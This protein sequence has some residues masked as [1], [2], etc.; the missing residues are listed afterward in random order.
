MVCSAAARGPRLEDE[1]SRPIDGVVSTI[2]PVSGKPHELLR[3]PRQGIVSA[4][5][6]AKTLYVGTGGG[7][8]LALDFTTA[9][10]RWTFAADQTILGIGASEEV[11]CVGAGGKLIAL[12]PVSGKTRWTYDNNAPA[13]DPVLADDGIVIINSADGPIALEQSTGT[14]RWRLNVRWGYFIVSPLRDHRVCIW[15]PDEI[16]VVD[17]RRGIELWE[18]AMDQSSAAPGAIP[19]P[20]FGQDDAIAQMRGSPRDARDWSIHCLDAANGRAAWVAAIG[21]HGG[22]SPRVY[23]DGGAVYCAADKILYALDPQNG[24]IRWQAPTGVHQTAVPVQHCAG[25]VLFAE[26]GGTLLALDARTGEKRWAA[27]P[28]DRE[29][30]T[31]VSMMAD[32]G[33]IVLVRNVE[34]GK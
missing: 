11:V 24:A 5:R 15:K 13:A 4:Q 26:T 29:I 21:D 34:V 17:T 14:I 3:L 1:Q 27:D 6:V 25:L 9:K 20:A 23:I 10:A 8:V 7:T 16:F 30:S 18:A 32:G 31:I 12:D 28:D 33:T 19:S 22:S 2:D